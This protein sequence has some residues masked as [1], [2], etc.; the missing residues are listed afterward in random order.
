MKASGL[1]INASK[2]F[3]AQEEFEYLGYWIAREG[4]LPVK[5]KISEFPNLKRGSSYAVS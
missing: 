4:I 1:K 2:S 3:F 5:K